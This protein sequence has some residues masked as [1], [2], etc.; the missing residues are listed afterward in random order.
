MAVTQASLTDRMMRAAKADVALYEEVEHDETATQQ[1]AIVVAIVA[2][3][4]AI[5]ALIGAAMGGRNVIGAIIIG[6]VGAFLGWII[7]SYVTYFVGTRFF[8]GTATP[9]E[10]LRTIGFAQAPGVLNI[11]S[12]IPVIGWLISLLAGIW[13]LWLG[14]VAVRQALDFDTGKA[15]LTV[16]IGWVI[17]LIINL[18]LLAPLA[19]LMR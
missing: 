14:I 3:A 10:L 4:S 1:A 6:L 5:G 15:V 13:S 2:I 11:L 19:L 17:V 16:I 9:G 7:W 12:F 8:G 18:V